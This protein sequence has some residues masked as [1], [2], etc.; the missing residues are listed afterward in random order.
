[1]SVFRQLSADFK[2]REMEHCGD[3]RC[4]NRRVLKSQV[5]GGNTRCEQM[6]SA[7]HPIADIAPRSWHVRFVPSPEVGRLRRRRAMEL[8]DKRKLDPKRRAAAISISCPYQ[9]AVRLDDSARDGQPHAHAF[10]FAGEE[11]FEDRFWFVFGN[12]RPAI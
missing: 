8:L 7:P 6:F 2:E 4:T 12:A 5:K 3:A 1:V 9:S 11:R 10:R